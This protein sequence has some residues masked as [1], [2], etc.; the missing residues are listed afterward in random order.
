MDPRLPEP[1]RHDE[2]QRPEGVSP[3]RARRRSEAGD[4][5]VLRATS[6]VARPEGDR[7]DRQAADRLRHTAHAMTP[8]TVSAP[9]AG[10]RR[11]WGDRAFRSVTLASG[12]LVLVLL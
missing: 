1:D 4:A 9:L 12:L 7:A 10:S 5:V 8:T 2:G 6:G 3:V 11:S